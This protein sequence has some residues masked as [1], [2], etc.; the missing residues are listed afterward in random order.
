VSPEQIGGERRARR[1]ARGGDGLAV[2][3]C[4][5][6]SGLR[7]E[8]DDHGLVCRPIRVAREERHELGRKSAGAWEVR[9]HDGKERVPFG[10]QRRD[11]R[12]H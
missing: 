10:D 4:G 5:W 9:R 3:Q 12:W 7:V 6:R 8:R 11:P 1:G 2:H